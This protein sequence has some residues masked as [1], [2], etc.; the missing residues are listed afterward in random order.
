MP[1]LGMEAGTPPA[2]G[3]RVQPKAR[4]SPEGA[5]TPQKKSQLKVGIGFYSLV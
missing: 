3:R 4:P 5:A 1:A 2:K